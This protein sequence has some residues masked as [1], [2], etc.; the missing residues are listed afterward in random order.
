MSRSFTALAILNRFDESCAQR[1]RRDSKRSDVVLEVDRLHDIGMGCARVHERS[2]GRLEER[3]VL[4]SARSMLGNLA[5][6]ARNDVLMALAATLRVVD[7]P[8]A[9]F[10]VLDLFEEEAVVVERPQRHDVRL[11]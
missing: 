5:R 4:H 11:G 9:V 8:Q 10:D 2:T 7:R 1:V 6:A 3:T